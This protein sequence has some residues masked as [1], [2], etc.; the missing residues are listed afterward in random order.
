[1]IKYYLRNKKVS[2][3]NISSFIDMKINRNQLQIHEYLI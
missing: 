1:M 3:Y 2:I